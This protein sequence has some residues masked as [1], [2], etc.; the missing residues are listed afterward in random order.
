MFNFRYR[1]PAHFIEVFRTWY[2]PIHK[3]FG[4]LSLEQA[5]SLNQD[6]TQLLIESNRAGTQTLIVPSEYL[7]IVIKKR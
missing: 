1:S 2:G 4:A 5:E 3:A 6:L 7:E